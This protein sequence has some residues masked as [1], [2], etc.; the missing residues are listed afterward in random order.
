VLELKTDLIKV[1][2]IFHVSLFLAQDFFYFFQAEFTFKYNIKQTSVCGSFFQSSKIYVYCPETVDSLEKY[3]NSRPFALAYF[4]VT[5]AGTSW[6]CFS[7]WTPISKPTS[8]DVWCTSPKMENV[9]PKQ[10][11]FD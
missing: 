6:K 5:K 2:Q 4:F 7:P 3:P 8:L 1:M 11:I 9:Y 10:N